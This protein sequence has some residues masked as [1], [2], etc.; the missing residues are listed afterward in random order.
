MAAED[1]LEALRELQHDLVALANSQLLNIERLWL[2]LEA[3][4]DA[5]RR[6]LDKPGRSEA[7]RVRVVSGMFSSPSSFFNGTTKLIH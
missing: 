1:H 7:S 5:F 3:N 6:L 2:N 4:I